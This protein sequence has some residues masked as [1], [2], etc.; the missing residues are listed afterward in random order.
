MKANPSIQKYNS[1]LAR[2][3]RAER[4]IK[5]LVALLAAAERE[6]ADAE[7]AR[8]EADSAFERSFKST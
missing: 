8:L 1:A 4:Q 5:K 3:N 2:R 6:R 7:A